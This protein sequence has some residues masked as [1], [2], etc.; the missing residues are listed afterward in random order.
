MNDIWLISDMHFG[1]TKILDFKRDDGITPLRDFQSIDHMHESL[2]D[3]WNSVVKTGDKVLVL[4][5]VAFS[6]KAYDVIMPK[7]NGNTKYLIRGNHDRFSETRY[8]NHFNKIHGV[9]VFEGFALTHVPIHEFSGSRWK[10]NI[11]G[12]THHRNIPDPF[13]FNVSCENINYTPINFEEIRDKYIELGVR[14][15]R[16]PEAVRD[17]ESS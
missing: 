6:T 8:R 13:Y 12:H 1:Q 7:L 9:Y 10:G 15:M 11:H 14:E 4:G 3:N 16:P 17:E 2:I 5:D